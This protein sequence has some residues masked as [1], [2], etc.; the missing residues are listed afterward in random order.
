ME[1]I[2]LAVVTDDKEYGR[3]L[4]LAMLSVCRSFIIRIFTAEEFLRESRDFDLVLWDGE[5][6][7]EAYGGRIIYLTEKSSE[8][9]NNLS[10]KKFC[11][12]KYST[13]AGM[14][15][16]MFEIY[17]VLTGRRA[18]NLRRQDV[19]LFVFASFA[20][21]TGCTTAAMSAAQE[22]CRFRG[23]RV[24]YI[25]FEELESTGDFIQ[26][27][28]GI[29]GSSVYLYELFNN[30]YKG[31]PE[32]RSFGMKSPFLD[33]YVVRDHFGVESFS[34]NSGR[35][36]LKELSND[37]I[38]KFMASIIDSGRYDIIIIDLGSALCR[39]A[40]KLL[41]MAEKICLIAT[42]G[43]STAKEQKYI[44]HITAHL[45]AEIMDKILKVDNNWYEEAVTMGKDEKRVKANCAEKP[46]KI[47]K[48][49]CFTNDEGRIGIFLDKE[50]GS[51]ISVL[52]EALVEPL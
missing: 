49:D 1:N 6:V 9:V 14:V 15:S 7:R 23:K 10:E 17:E 29:K 36:P 11:V 31:T 18:V 24:F 12:Y 38:H 4:S 43:K 27:D 20:G 26:C 52:T 41:E 39:S 44:T 34:Q 47:S 16:S 48:C 40:L 22:F 37:E 25:S 30:I 32:N 21:G 42:Y 45:G 35:N 3:S 8:A 5:E 13:A 33:K 2:F 51:D 50:F 46:I 28:K 19:R